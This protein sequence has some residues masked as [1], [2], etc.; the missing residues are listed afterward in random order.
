[1][2][3]DAANIAD[4]SSHAERRLVNDAFAQFERITSGFSSGRAGIP[5]WVSFAGYRILGEV[6]RG[7]Q[8][9][10]YQALHE[11]TRRKVAIK[12]LKEGPFADRTELARFDRE[13]DVLSRLNHP[14][15]VAV[16]DRGLTAG[17]AWYVMDYV[18]GR[19]LDAYVAGADL[20][21]D[22]LLAL[23]VKVCDAVNVAHLRGVIHRDL[24]PGN[25]RVDEQG[26]PRILDFG[27]AKLVHEHPGGS[28]ALAMTM[29]GQ[30]VGSLPWSSPEQTTGGADAIDIR[31]D[32]YSLGVILFQLL[33]GRF[34]YP[35]VGRIDDVVRHIAQTSPERPSTIRRGLDHDL[36]L[37]VLKCLAKEPERRYQS[38]GELARDIRHYLANEPVEATSPSASYRLRKFVRRNR[39]LVL[40][41]A[42]IAATLVI[43]AIVSVAF[44]LSEARQ[45]RAAEQTLS[46]AEKAEGEAKARAGELEKVAKF[47]EAQLAG[48]DAETMGARLRADLV[49]NVR[50]A[51]E[52][53][54]LPPDDVVAR[55]GELERIIAG[56]D[57][58]G[59]ALGSLNENVF[60]PALEA[61]EREF[62][63]QP[64]LKARLLQTL[65]ATL[66]E[67][68]LIEAAR[69]PQVEALTI[70]R[71][72]LGDEAADTIESIDSM[73]ALLN[74]EGKL[75]EAE[76]HWRTSLAT[77]RRV[78]GNDDPKTLIAISN[79]G[80]AL[81]TQGKLAEA[82]PYHR[83]ALAGYRSMLGEDHPNTLVAIHNLGMLL[84]AQGKPA[85]AEPL[86]RDA[87]EKSRRVMGD[88]NV[89][90]LTSINAM[91][92]LLEAQGRLAEAER[93]DREALGKL[94][95]VMGNDHPNTL[96]SMNNLAVLL[97]A[98]GRIPEAEPLCREA[99]DGRRRV[100]GNDHVN[101]LISISTM[102]VLLKAQG[103]LA[104]AEPYYRESM[105]KHRRLRGDE[106]PNTLIAI[107][108]MGALLAAEGRPAEAEALYREALEKRRRVLGDG[109]PGTLATLN[110]L[111][112][113]LAAQGKYTEGVALLVP[114]EPA[115]RRE[116]KGG[117]AAQLG[118]FLSTLGRARVGVGELDD[119]EK[120]LTEADT[121]LSKADRATERDRADV[122][123]GLADLYDA[124]HAA[125]P[126]K[127]F[128]KAAAEWRTKLN[129]A[130]ATTRSSAP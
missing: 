60:H 30:F 39:V 65:A 127:G 122:W 14:H 13:V 111:A 18:P 51:A 55:I 29:T 41:G 48:I 110:S 5:D 67:L 46:R 88:D 92:R 80:T 63:G 130:H 90:T 126:D 76:S 113:V 112:D 26:E 23:F 19:P 72:E 69:R 45:R 24:K 75:A 1:M 93:F 62:A 82:E 104:E 119:A 117:N 28:S 125:D 95:R 101:T 11:S 52:R 89:Q 123:R 102:G 53:S 57:F 99:L 36:E 44:G 38:A 107:H 43:S 34:P 91:G 9:V 115:A 98:Q 128:D 64:L 94:R 121:I 129:S 32:V 70:R 22:A 71:R 61:I 118:R 35:V 4:T 8:G 15:I 50:A 103:K 7:G 16:H 20:S 86:L 10:V 105:E 96:A 97:W 87:L 6:H 108:N 12:V 42:A 56:S 81:R 106:H 25:I 109:H 84:A 17:H 114:A 120:N 31:T 59:M 27:L 37:I 77:A 79:L 73:G 54:Q 100:L 68:G 2:N 83:E 116:F 74:A 66:Q 124:R 3:R 21:M 78:L 49:E 85:D 58:T 33:T 47:Q 40:A